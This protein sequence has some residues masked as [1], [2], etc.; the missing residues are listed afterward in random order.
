MRLSSRNV[1]DGGFRLRGAAEA[2]ASLS[3]GANLSPALASSPCSWRPFDVALCSS[4]SAGAA[5][6][7]IAR[8][9]AGYDMMT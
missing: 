2:N 5:S 9:S 4:V 6:W 8:L 1:T 3:P 7:Q